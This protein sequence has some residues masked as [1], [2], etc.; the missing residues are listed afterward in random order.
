MNPSTQELSYLDRVYLGSQ[1]IVNPLKYRYNSSAYRLLEL[2][3]EAVSNMSVSEFITKNFTH[4]FGMHQ[5]TFHG[6]VDVPNRLR[7]EL[8]PELCYPYHYIK[9]NEVVISCYDPNVERTFGAADMISTVEDL[10]KWNK[11][12]FS[13]RV[14]NTSKERSNR[15][16]QLMLGLYTVDEEGD[17]YYGYGIKTY[18]RN[19]KK[20]YWHEGLV[21][22]ASVYL[23]YDPETDTQVV[24]IS[25]TTGVSFN[26]KTGTYI[27]EHLNDGV[28]E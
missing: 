21:T 6:G 25:N 27:F 2:I 3:I 4:P 9:K 13:G 10:C 17:S 28:F 5:T 15:L 11:A 23:E 7:H 20:I 16:L 26:A 14:F 24:V 1:S 22:G 18:V 8:C 12:L 19:G